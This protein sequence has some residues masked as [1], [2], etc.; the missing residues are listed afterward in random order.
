MR[1]VT[2]YNVKARVASITEG[3][4]IIHGKLKINIMPTEE[5]QNY[6]EIVPVSKDL[7]F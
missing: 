3:K 7:P 2:K 4:H 1:P 5:R 6:A